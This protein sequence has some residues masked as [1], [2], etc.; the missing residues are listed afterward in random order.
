MAKLSQKNIYLFGISLNSFELA[1]NDKDNDIDNNIDNDND[2]DND[3][4]NDYDIDDDDYNKYVD[5]NDNQ[6]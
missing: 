2:D 4:N 3:D 6:E 5:K 1:V